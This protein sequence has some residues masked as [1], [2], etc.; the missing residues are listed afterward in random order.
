VDFKDFMGQTV[1]V[2]HSIQL[3][4]C[5][6]SDSQSINIL[7]LSNN[8]P[9]ANFLRLFPNPAN[10]MVELSGIT[11][12]VSIEICDGMG[13]IIIQAKCSVNSISIP[14][15][16]LPRGIYYVRISNEKYRRTIPF[17]RI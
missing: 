3:N 11:N 8:I 2:K 10:T 4:G 12:P 16:I 14:V 1:K 13:R 6:A 5:E 9:A 15:E 17:T 7:N